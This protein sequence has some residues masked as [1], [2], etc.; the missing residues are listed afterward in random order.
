MAFPQ[1]RWPFGADVNNSES[2]ASVDT[3]RRRARH[4]LMGASVLVVI[5]V[6]AFPWMFDTQPRPVALDVPI[7]IPDKNQVAALALPPVDTELKVKTEVASNLSPAATLP[8]AL[9]ATLP[10]ASTAES[11]VAPVRDLN[12]KGLAPGEEEVTP[13]SKD[14]KEAKEAKQSK[15]SKEVKDP[16]PDIKPE[17]KPEPKQEAK[18]EPKP[19]SDA[20]NDGARAQSLLDGG[21]KSADA[22]SSDANPSRYVVQVAAFSDAGK[23]HEVRQKLEKAGIKT[24]SQAVD[25]PDGKRYRVRIGPFTSKA[26]AEQAAGKVKTHQLTAVVLT[27]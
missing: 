13:T 12:S 7:A 27:L 17:I 25:T 9:P 23:A 11:R 5:G 4:R 14:V 8:A 15:E 3:L 26:E 2:A 18:T 22:K 16:K 24:Y 10:P 20:K 21:A 1:F 6:V 19:K